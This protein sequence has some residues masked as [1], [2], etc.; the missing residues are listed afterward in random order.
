VNHLACASATADP[1]AGTSGSEM[2]SQHSN[3]SEFGSMECGGGLR[4]TVYP[5]RKIACA[6]DP[7]CQSYP[8]TMWSSSGVG[9]RLLAL[10]LAVRSAFMGLFG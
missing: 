9:G 2:A 8:R 1:Q 3:L 7:Y 10:S 4:L 6:H 5:H